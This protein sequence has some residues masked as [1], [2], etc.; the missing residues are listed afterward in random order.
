MSNALWTQPRLRL[1]GTQRET[2][3]LFVVY[4]HRRRFASKKRWAVPQQEWRLCFS[5]WTSI[6]MCDGSSVTV[7]RWGSALVRERR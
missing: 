6:F 3:R 2:V 7:H 5:E 1:T 4:K